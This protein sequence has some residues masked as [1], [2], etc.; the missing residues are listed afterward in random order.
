MSYK[1]TTYQSVLF[2][3]PKSDTPAPIGVLDYANSQLV[4]LTGSSQSA[5]ALPAGC[6]LACIANLG[7]N[8]VHIRG[9]D[10]A[11]TTAA[12]ALLGGTVDVFVVTATTRVIRL[13]GTASDTVTITPFLP[14]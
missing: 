11:A 12:P 10:V 4:T 13:I 2:R 9:D 5:T 1:H 7:S 3:T 14:G 8:P 6:H